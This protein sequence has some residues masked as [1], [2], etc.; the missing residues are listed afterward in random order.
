ML[1][2]DVKVR[3]DTQ[4]ISKSERFNYLR[5]KIQGYRLIHNDVTNCIGTARMKRRLASGVMGDKKIPPKHKEDASGEM[6]MLRWMC[7]HTKSEKIRNEY[8]RD[9]V[10]VASVV[11]KMRE[12]RLRWFGHVKRCRMPHCYVFFGFAA[13]ELRV[14][15][16]H[17]ST[18]TR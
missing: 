13:L 11:D 1:E 14:L 12:G 6:R 16:K 8:I 10:G 9:K 18:S 2:T 4:V 17:L 7:R 15:R 3:L 5:S